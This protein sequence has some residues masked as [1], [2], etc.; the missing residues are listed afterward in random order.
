MQPVC[1]FGHFTYFNG[2]RCPRYRNERRCHVT[3]TR[4]LPP[5]APFALLS[6]PLLP[7]YID[8]LSP[9]L[10]SV[11][12]INLLYL[13]LSSFILSL[14]FCTDPFLFQVLPPSV[15]FFFHIALYSLLSPFP[16]LCYKQSFLLQLQIT[17]LLLQPISPR[18]MDHCEVTRY[19]GLCCSASAS[20][21]AEFSR[22]SPSLPGPCR[23]YGSCHTLPLLP[24]DV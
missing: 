12:F 6:P 1:L 11:S 7:R 15:Y 21:R 19:P 4:V 20:G 10:F 16:S 22:P 17:C 8:K 2:S 18:A 23:E 3:F 24:N 14:P 9:C 5:I 13:L